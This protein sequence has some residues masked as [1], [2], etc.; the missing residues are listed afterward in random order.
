MELP[1]NL[2]QSEKHFVQ[3]LHTQRELA[4][5]T[6]EEADIKAKLMKI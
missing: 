5:L 4:I 6:I 2:A 1:T 3:F